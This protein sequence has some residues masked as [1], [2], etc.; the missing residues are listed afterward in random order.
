MDSFSEFKREEDRV[1]FIRNSRQECAKRM[2][3]IQDVT[4]VRN[5]C[6]FLCACVQKFKI[7]K[8]RKINR[9]IFCLGL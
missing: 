8:L 7:I 9:L 4:N 1:V 2:I 6:T 3:A 5:S